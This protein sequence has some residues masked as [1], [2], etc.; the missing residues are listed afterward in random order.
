MSFMNAKKPG[1]VAQ[2]GGWRKLIFW[3]V[4]ALVIS[5]ILSWIGIGR[6]DA[7]CVESDGSKCGS[8]ASVA[9]AFRD[10]QLRNSKDVMLP[11]NVRRAANRWAANQTGARV[12][13]AG[14]INDWWNDTLR[15]TNCMMWG[16]T[17][18]ACTRPGWFRNSTDPMYQGMKE[19]SRM[20]VTCAGN[21]IL[22]GVSTETLRN[23]IRENPEEVPKTVR[24]FVR[25][26]SGRMFWAT[27]GV[28]G[29][30][31]MYN[32]LKDKMGPISFFGF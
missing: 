16:G 21:A 15:K 22:T 17:R 8:T 6:A 23:L 30:K 27:A 25:S 2:V 24:Q 11:R 26:F 20:V 12:V 9:A 7:A 18:S 31:C 10:G 32:K 4:V 5:T 19:S 13:A 14:P 3:L 29:T 1:L 28:G